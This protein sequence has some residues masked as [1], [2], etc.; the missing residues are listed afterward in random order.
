ML[1]V[2]VAVA[3]G[4]VK[5]ALRDGYGP[6]LPVTVSRSQRVGICVGLTT[7]PV[8]DYR[9]VAPVSPVREEGLGWAEAGWHQ[10][11]VVVFVAGSS[12]VY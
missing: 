12:R 10:P 9:A 4:R 11:G 3:L 8:S 1:S 5:D 2:A 7:P 6:L